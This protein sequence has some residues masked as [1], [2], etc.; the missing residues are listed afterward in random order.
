MIFNFRKGFD[1]EVNTPKPKQPLIAI[2]A[3]VI[4]EN[5]SLHKAYC[6][7]VIAA[8]GVPIIIPYVSDYTTLR[9]LLMV[10]VVDFNFSI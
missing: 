2:S 1:G 10:F 8:G 4:G 5:S 9:P 3:N 7:S 6:E